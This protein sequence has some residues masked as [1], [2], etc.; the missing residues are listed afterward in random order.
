MPFRANWPPGLTATAKRSNAVPK[1]KSGALQFIGPVYRVK[2]MSDRSEAG[3]L[4]EDPRREGRLEV[5]TQENTRQ[6]LGPIY[7]RCYDR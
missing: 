5:T 2:S 3:N 1:G 4:L 6:C 7:R